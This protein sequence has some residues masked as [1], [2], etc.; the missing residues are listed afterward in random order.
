VA[1]QQFGL[2]FRDVRKP[3]FESFGNA[4]MKCQSRL[5]QHGNNGVAQ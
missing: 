4:S 2:G 3:V 5:A 1:H